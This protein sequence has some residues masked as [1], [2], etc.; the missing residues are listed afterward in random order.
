MKKVRTWE[1]LDDLEKVEALRKSI[2]NW[3]N[4]LFNVDYG[5]VIYLDNGEMI[6]PHDAGYPKTYYDSVHKILDKIAELE[7]KIDEI[8]SR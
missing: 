1:D 5:K 6:V 2:R 3:E 8:L 7:A 4:D